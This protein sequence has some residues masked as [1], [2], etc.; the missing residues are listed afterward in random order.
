[1]RLFWAMQDAMRRARGQ[2]GGWAWVG[3]R[4]A[5]DAPIA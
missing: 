1:V 2:Q 4:F 3:E 5:T